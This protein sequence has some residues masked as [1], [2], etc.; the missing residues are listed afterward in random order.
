MH[1]VYPDARMVYLDRDGRDV[2]VSDRFRN[3]VKE[4]Y[5]RRG[6]DRLIAELRQNP[7]AFISGEKSIF[8]EAW[9]RG[10]HQGVPSWRENL[11]ESESEGKRLYAERFFPIRYEDILSNPFA[12]MKKL[13]L[14]PGVKGVD[15]AL[16]ALLRA[17]IADNPDQKWQAE[18]NQSI[19]AILSKGQPGSWRKFFNKRDREVFKEIAGELLVKWRYESNLLR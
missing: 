7:E 2:M 17:E 6:D 12:E 3:F 16:E 13:W 10:V 14:F 8:T 9:L 5:L 15:P 18:R 4:K 11:V 19:P 1:Q